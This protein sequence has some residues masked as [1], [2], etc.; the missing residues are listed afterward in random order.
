MDNSKISIQMWIVLAY[1]R[2]KD[3]NSGYKNSGAMHH[4]METFAG[5][6]VSKYLQ[7]LKRRG[8]VRCTDGYWTITDDGLAAVANLGAN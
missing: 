5:W 3:V 7:A 4:Y 6:P 2:H 1:L 8:L